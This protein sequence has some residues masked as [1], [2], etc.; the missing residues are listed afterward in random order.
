MK[1]LKSSFDAVHAISFFF[2]AILDI[3]R[4]VFSNRFLAV[5]IR[6]CLLS[7]KKK[8]DD[9]VLAVKQ[10]RSLKNLLSAIFYF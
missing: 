5:T 2:I 9:M 1:F 3:A 7:I 8:S 10:D 6:H 4:L